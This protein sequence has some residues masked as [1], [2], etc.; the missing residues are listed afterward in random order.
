MRP[1]QHT[2]WADAQEAQYHA[3]L[4]EQDCI[5]HYCEQ[6]VADWLDGYVLLGRRSVDALDEFG[7]LDAA[8]DALVQDYM[9]DLERE[10]AECRAEAHAH[11]RGWI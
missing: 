1:G 6:M 4:H 3:D 9:K 5:D 10:A 11:N 8:A 2:A 7:S